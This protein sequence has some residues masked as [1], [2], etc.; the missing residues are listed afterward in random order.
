MIVKFDKPSGILEITQILDGIEYKK[1]YLNYTEKE[2][3]KKF[4]EYV[5]KQNE[6][7]SRKK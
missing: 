7:I 4:N 2:A 5:R 1:K 3:V 6:K